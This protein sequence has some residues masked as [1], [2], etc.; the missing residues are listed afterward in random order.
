MFENNKSLC[1]AV[2][3]IFIEKKTEISKNSIT[4]AI[5]YMPKY[6]L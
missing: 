6:N 4:I 3:L 5:L 1:N 2:D